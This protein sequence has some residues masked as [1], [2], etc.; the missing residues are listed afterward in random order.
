MATVYRY[1]Y[2][3]SRTRGTVRIDFYAASAVTL[4]LDGGEVITTLPAPSARVLEDFGWAFDKVQYGLHSAVGGKVKFSLKTFNTTAFKTFLQSYRYTATTNIYTGTYDTVNQD[5]LYGNVM[6]VSYCAYGDNT[7]YTQWYGIQ[8]SCKAS[9]TDGTIECEYADALQHCMKQVKWESLQRAMWSK[10]IDDN[11]AYREVQYGG[12]GAFDWVW[13]ADGVTKAGA[14]SKLWGYFGHAVQGDP[15]NWATGAQSH[16]T[17]MPVSAFSAV[18]ETCV[19]TAFKQAI[20][21]GTVTFDVKGAISKCICG[22]DGGTVTISGITGLPTA[23]AELFKQD[24]DQTPSYGTYLTNTTTYVLAFINSAPVSVIAALSLSRDPDFTIVDELRRTYQTPWD[25]FVDLFKSAFKVGTISYY[26]TAPTC[27]VTASYPQDTASPTDITSQIRN[28]GD[29]ALGV[30]DA[31]TGQ[32]TAS[33]AFAIANDIDNISF[34]EGAGRNDSTY[35]IPVIFSTSPVACDYEGYDGSDPDNFRRLNTTVYNGESG[36]GHLSYNTRLLGLYYWDAPSD[37]TVTE[38]D[39]FVHDTEMPVR[40]YSSRCFHDAV[41]PQVP[42]ASTLTLPQTRITDNADAQSGRVL[43]LA[44]QQEMGTMYDLARRF[45]ELYWGEYQTLITGEL[46]T[47]YTGAHSTKMLQF[48]PTLLPFTVT[49]SGLDA[50]ET[51][52][53]VCPTLYHITSCKADAEGSKYKISLW[54]KA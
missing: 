45:D 15:S 21:E 32:A 6:R 40:V 11:T 39:A 31:V 47:D 33:T 51:F 48:N 43:A 1:E 35:T 41:T 34:T 17:F 13:K 37:G 16:H 9:Y 49:P 30:D 53:S 29:I 52:W 38:N 42:V 26:G 25:L 10:V 7:F 14:T 27:T 46:P 22:H 44:D 20:R 19:T 36:Y 23:N 50:D 28:I 4:A 12:G 8:Q 18:I 3:D 5:V 54:G 2:T 24:Y